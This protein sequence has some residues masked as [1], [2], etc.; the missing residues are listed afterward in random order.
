MSNPVPVAPDLFVWPSDHPQLIGGSC[1]DCETV[2]F[3]LADGCPKCGSEA[4]ERTLLP[5]DGR[6]WTWT[7]QGFLPKEPYLGA[8]HPDDFEPW[9]VGLV[10]LGGA[11]RVE[12]RVVGADID[13]LRIGDPMTT[14]VVPFTKDAA[15]ND[16]VTFAFAPADAPSEKE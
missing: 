12:G 14:V 10:E 4:V 13:R 7:S 2:S 1:Q 16:I 6:L 3:P 9:L 5:A 15:G 11:I 8:S